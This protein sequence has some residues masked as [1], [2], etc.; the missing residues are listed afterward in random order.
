MIADAG[1]TVRQAIRQKDTPYAELGLDDP[2]LS[3]DQLVDASWRS[4][5]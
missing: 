3:D 5:S 1:L 2:D 4:R